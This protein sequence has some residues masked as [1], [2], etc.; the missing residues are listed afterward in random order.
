MFFALSLLKV[1]TTCLRTEKAL[2]RLRLCAVSPEPFL[3]TYV[4]STLFSRA[5]SNNNKISIKQ[6]RRL[7]EGLDGRR[8]QIFLNR[9]M[10]FIDMRIMPLVLNGQR[11]KALYFSD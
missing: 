2:A 7:N 8:V 6:N 4:I 5:G 9:W 3:V 1:S 10:G 11:L